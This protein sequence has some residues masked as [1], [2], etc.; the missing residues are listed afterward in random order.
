MERCLIRN[1]WLSSDLKGATG[2]SQRPVSAAGLWVPLAAVPWRSQKLEKSIAPV[3]ESTSA[4]GS[5]MLFFFQSLSSTHKGQSLTS[6][7]LAKKNDTRDHL[8]CCRQ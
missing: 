8:Y 3:S 2:D 7:Q 4:L 6:F 1:T 5:R